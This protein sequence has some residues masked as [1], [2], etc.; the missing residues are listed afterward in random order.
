MK[1]FL[2]W[3][4]VVGR[5]SNLTVS[6][7]RLAYYVKIMNLKAGCTC[8]NGYFSGGIQ[9]IITLFCDILVAVNSR[10]RFL[11]SLITVLEI[12]L[13][14]YLFIYRYHFTLIARSPH[15]FEFYFCCW[16]EIYSIHISLTGIWNTFS[17]GVSI[18]ILT[19]SF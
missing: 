13:F 19:V 2:L 9:L 3:A 16:I 4:R 17:F 7:R 12:Y 15:W 10:R 6:R 18:S 1:C 8:R 14:I 5:T 11:N